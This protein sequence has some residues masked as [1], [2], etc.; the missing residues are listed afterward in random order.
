MLVAETFTYFP[1][2]SLGGKTA[3]WH[4]SP[5]PL[6][7]HVVQQIFILPIN[8]VQIISVLKNESTQL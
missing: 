2:Y 8:S 5:H 3:F 6:L 1:E 4:S 7:K